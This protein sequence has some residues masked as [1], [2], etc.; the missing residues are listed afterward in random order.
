M[1][2]RSLGLIAGAGRA[3]RVSSA[4]TDIERRNPR[5][6]QAIPTMYG[7]VQFRSRLE[8][9]WAVFFD[10][11]GWPWVYEPLDLRRYIPDFI[12]SFEAGPIAVEVKPETM[13]APLG[14]YAQR[15]VLS[16]WSRELL[17]IGAA[18]HGDVIGV[19]GDPVGGMDSGRE[20]ALGPAE[21]FACINCGRVSVL[22]ADYSWR[23]R[24]SGCYGGNSHR[25]HVD[26]GYVAGAWL[27][28]GNRVQW[29]PPKREVTR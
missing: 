21:I 6:I 3:R 19:I 22:N 1:A 14:E 23:C 24:V 2:P 8:A 11:V 26:E 27:A 28:A 25:G 5:T 7:G 9:R 29:N 12:L 15:M 10:T 16:G 20:V 17:V 18:V 13:L 4:P